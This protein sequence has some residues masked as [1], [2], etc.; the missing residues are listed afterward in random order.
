MKMTAGAMRGSGTAAFQ[1]A[2]NAQWPVS[3]EQ[4]APY[5]QRTMRQIQPGAAAEITLEN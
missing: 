3:I 5:G 4:T 2:A 1:R